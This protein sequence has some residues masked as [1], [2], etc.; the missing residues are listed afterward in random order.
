MN[1]K[2]LSFALAAIK[3]YRWYFYGML[4]SVLWVSTNVNLQ[5]YFTKLIINAMVDKDFERIINIAIWYVI[6]QFQFAFAWRLYDSCCVHTNRMR[7]DIANHILEKIKHHDVVFFYNQLAGSVSSKIKDAATLIPN[8]IYAVVD[9]YVRIGLLIIV[10]I[11]LLAT[12][13]WLFSIALF[14]WVAFF[15][16]VFWLNVKKMNALSEVT[17]ECDAK[18]WGGIVDCLSNM[19]SV[20]YF[21]SSAYEAK[22]LGKAQQAYNHGVLVKGRFLTP[23]YFWLGMAFS[24]YIVVCLGILIY[25]YRLELITPGDFAFVFAINYE[26]IDQL[27]ALTHTLRDFVNNWGTAEQALSILEVVPQVQDKPQA[28]PL[29]VTK[30]EIAFQKVGF[31]YEG[32]EDLFED[33][34]ITI[35]PKQKVGLVGYSGGGKST[36][37][38]LILRLYDVNAGRI[39]LDSQDIR[40]VTQ[41][42]LRSAIS[43]IPQDPALFHRSLMENIRYGKLDASDEEVI[44]AA[45]K[46]HAHEFIMSFPEQYQSLV[47]ERG[48]KLSGGQRQRIAIARAILKDAPILIFDEAT[49]QLDSITENDIQESLLE[50]MQGKTAIVIAHRL[51]TLLRMDRILVFE[52]GKIIEDGSHQALFEKQG[53]YRTLWDTQVG[54]FLRDRVTKQ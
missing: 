6:L 33:K 3:P 8:M 25:L 12:T 29:V 50:C 45:K 20:K 2:V 10:A 44:S 4:F 42:S 39:L 36:F 16:G 53:V 1:N 27:F 40:E 49:S 5:N 54:G 17:A 24:S 30:R 51:S 52:A 47:G 13:H 43:M 34:S 31:H 18:V 23:F 11:V 32:V 35:L 7:M 38:N 41:D 15:L 9:N 21:S 22:I 46:A 26:I 28:P 19:V 48:V 37:V 14:L